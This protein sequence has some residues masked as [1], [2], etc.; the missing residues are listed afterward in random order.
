MMAAQHFKACLE[1]SAQTIKAVVACWLNVC[2]EQAASAVA[3]ALGHGKAPLIQQR[4]NCLHHNLYALVETRLFGDQ[5][6]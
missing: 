5:A 1:S 4:H 6:L 2:M 3:V